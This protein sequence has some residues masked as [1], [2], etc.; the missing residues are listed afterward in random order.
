MELWLRFYKFQE[1]LF[2]GMLEGC[3]AKAGLVCDFL[4]ESVL[5]G[6]PSEFFKIFHHGYSANIY[7][8]K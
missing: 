4:K 1:E 7:L 6:G 8:F 2:R 5:T 3:S